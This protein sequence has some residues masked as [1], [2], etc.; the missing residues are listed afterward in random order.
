MEHNS[1]FFVGLVDF[2]LVVSG[3]PGLIGPT[4]NYRTIYIIGLPPSG[5]IST[6]PYY[7]GYRNYLLLSCYQ[8]ILSLVV[9][10]LSC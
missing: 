5:P 8:T 2:W 1:S 4:P 9:I 6:Y 7:L 10:G 3:P